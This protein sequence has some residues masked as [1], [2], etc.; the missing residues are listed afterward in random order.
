MKVNNRWILTT[1]ENLPDIE[2][3]SILLALYLRNIEV[4][5]LVIGSHLKLRVQWTSKS[6]SLCEVNKPRPLL[7]FNA[8]GLYY[9][10]EL[11]DW[12]EG[13]GTTWLLRLLKINPIVK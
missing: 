3:H 11:L 5:G 10:H 9:R 13:I 2:V 1:L 4:R 12:R 8:D 6:V 7:V